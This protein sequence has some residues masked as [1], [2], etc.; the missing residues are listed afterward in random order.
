[1]EG[2]IRRQQ[3][4]GQARIRVRERMIEE[5]RAAIHGLRAA[6]QAA[7]TQPAAVSTFGQTGRLPYL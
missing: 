1:M 4:Q 3:A 6:L 5:Q 2:Q 7:T